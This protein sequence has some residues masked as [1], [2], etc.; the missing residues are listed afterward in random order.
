M[1]GRRKPYAIGTQNEEEFAKNVAKGNSN[2]SNTSAGSN[3]G[4]NREGIKKPFKGIKPGMS[5]KEIDEQLKKNNP[6]GRTN[7]I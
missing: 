3:G 5:K 1:K 2:K 4:V 6:E 7:P